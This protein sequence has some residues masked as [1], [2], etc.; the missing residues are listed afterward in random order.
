MEFVMA[1][2]VT[3]ASNPTICAVGSCDV[4]LCG[5]HHVNAAYRHDDTADGPSLTGEQWSG[6]ENSGGN[7]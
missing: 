6:E 2:V 5:P 4:A 1:C 7:Q 3:S